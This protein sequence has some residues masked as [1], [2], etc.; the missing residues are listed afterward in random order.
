M[1]VC[2]IL[3]QIATRPEN[4]EKLF[5]ELK[6]V[7]PDPDTQ[8]TVPLLD[9]CHYMKAFIKEVLRMYSTVIG[10]GRTLQQDTVICGYNIP[11]GVQLVFPNLVLGTMEEYVTDAA[12]FRPERWLKPSQGGFSGKLHPYAYLPYG[13][14]ARMCLG[15]RFADLEMQVLLAKVRLFFEASVLDSDRVRFCRFSCSASSSSNTITNRSNTK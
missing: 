8:L 5:A 2:S 1:A 10:N 4:Q 11:K 15:R 3:Y 13:H 9:K 6:Q 7:M 12:C 14:G